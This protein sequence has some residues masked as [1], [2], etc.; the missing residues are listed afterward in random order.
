M[1]VALKLAAKIDVTRQPET[2]E[3]RYAVREL[4]TALNRLGYYKPDPAI[5]MNDA[6]D[7][8]FK[9]AI[10]AY[11]RKSTIFFDDVWLGPGSRTERILNGDPAATDDHGL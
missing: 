7:E 1:R 11:Q 2:E 9:D 3:G 10:Y 4:K 6:I 8:N 5:G